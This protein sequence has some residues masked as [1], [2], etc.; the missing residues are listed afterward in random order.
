MLETMGYLHMTG[1]NRKNGYEY[2]IKAWEEYE[3]LKKDINILDEHLEKL[4]AKQNGDIVPTARKA[5]VTS[6]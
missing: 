2:Q 4:Q 6:V 5:S 1:G 3:L